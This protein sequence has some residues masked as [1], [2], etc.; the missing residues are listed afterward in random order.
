MIH[1]FN[2]KIHYSEELKTLLRS[3]SELVAPF[4]GCTLNYALNDVILNEF[5]PTD[6]LRR[7]KNQ[8]LIKF[9]DQEVGDLLKKDDGETMER[10]AK[11]FSLNR[12]I[13]KE[14]EIYR[15]KELVLKER[16]SN[17]I[18]LNA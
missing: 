7:H 12:A 14:I 1:V 6:I 10:L 18:F 8:L 11:A 16:P 3:Y 9:H 13:M 4:L 2:D 15:T 17:V 5:D